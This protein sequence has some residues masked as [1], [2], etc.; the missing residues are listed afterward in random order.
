M[1]QLTMRTLYQ[2]AL[3]FVLLC[4]QAGINPVNS[5][6]VFIDDRSSG[7]LQSSS[8]GEW[9]LVTDRVM[10]GRS[11]GELLADHYLGNSCLR[12]R[13]LVSTANNGGF[14]QMALDLAGGEHYEASAQDGIELEVA[15]NGE[16]Y[17]LQLRTS[18]LWLPRQA[19][20]ARFNA[21]PQWCKIRI[22]FN[23]FEAYR[24]SSRFQAD[25]LNRIGVVAIGRDFKADLCLAGLCLYR[26]AG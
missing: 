8:A 14:V 13:G 1:M 20:R 21:G 24:T 22:P 17:N 10:G 19:Y 7:T 18:N 6:T 9:R 5:G 3:D 11:S 4:L 25:K 16:H 12:L 26:N 15:G 23:E 2:S